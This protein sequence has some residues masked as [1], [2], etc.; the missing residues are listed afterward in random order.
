MKYLVT[1]GAGFIGS[2]IVR[3]LIEQGKSVRVI[4]N[5][6]SGRR[7][8]IEPI[9]DQIEF[10]EGDVRDFWTV[11]RAVQGID[12][13]MHQAALPSVQRS[14]DNPLTSNEVNINGTLNLLEAARFH[15][16]KRFVYASS[17]SIYGDTEV[18]P[19]NESMPPS[20]LSP[21]AISK[22][23]GENYCRI[24]YQ[25]YG[26]ETVALRYFNVFGPNQNPYSQYSAVIPKMITALLKG[27]Q[28]T[29]YGD[30]EQSRDFTYIDNVVNANLL[31][32]RSEGGVGKVMNIAC[33][34]E[35][36][37]NILMGKL[38]SIIGSEIKPI[39]TDSKPG[40]IKR[41]LADISLAREN[42]KY[43]TTVG[44]DEGLLK[45][46]EYFRSTV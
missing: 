5:F 42:L 29:I 17:S 6:S 30:G 27:K 12:Y 18:M 10:I 32:C 28:P 34:D 22:L 15:K 35:Y 46:V 40:D 41:S 39:Y 13:V 19:K 24:F 45:T 3:K 8:N 2:N 7:S 37:L 36:S 44:L 25:L 43:E 1:G 38:N 11:N 16:V 4:D 20:P 14:I 31:A 23:A 21:Y 26:L 33:G 9:L